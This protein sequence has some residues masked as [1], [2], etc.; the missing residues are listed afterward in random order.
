MNAVQI[1]PNTKKNVEALKKADWLVVG[2]VYPDE[3]GSRIRR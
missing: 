1:G 3:T 2:E